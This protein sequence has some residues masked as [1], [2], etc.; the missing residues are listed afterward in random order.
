MELNSFD[1][2]KKNSKSLSKE[3]DFGFFSPQN[4]N[5]RNAK[6][7]KLTEVYRSFVFEVH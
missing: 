4:K 1:K 7:P 5:L 6:I 2:I 3:L